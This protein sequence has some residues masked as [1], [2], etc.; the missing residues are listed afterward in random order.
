MRVTG[1]CADLGGQIGGGVN[2]GGGD[3]LGENGAV[4]D[5]AEIPGD[6]AGG[7]RRGGGRGGGLGGEEGGGGE[8]GVVVFGFAEDIGG[9]EVGFGLELSR[10]RGGD[11][12][13]ARVVV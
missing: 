12:A 5:E 11:W 4:L 8:E 13:V 1:T 2:E 10:R 3:A 7:G 9:A 6:E